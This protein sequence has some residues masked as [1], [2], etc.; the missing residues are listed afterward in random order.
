[1]PA[2]EWEALVPKS[3]AQRREWSVEG[4]LGQTIGKRKTIDAM[5]QFRVTRQTF[6]WEL[7]YP[8]AASVPASNTDRQTAFE[9][10]V[11]SDS[12]F[13][14]THA[15]PK[16]ERVGYASVADFFAGYTWTHSQAGKSLLTVG[17]RTEYTVLTPVVDPATGNLY[18]NFHPVKPAYAPV[19]QLVETDTDFF[20]SV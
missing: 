10:A 3:I 20:G 4:Q 11:R 9:A 5:R 2:A 8:D 19:L 15:Y 7:G 17:T 16:Y 6:T 18:F 14:S 12:T 1:V 13:S